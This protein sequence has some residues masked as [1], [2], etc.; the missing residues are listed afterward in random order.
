[1]SAAD[2]TGELVK[3]V[4]LTCYRLDLT[5][6]AAGDNMGYRPSNSDD[7]I[8]GDLGKDFLRGG[9]GGHLVA[10]AEALVESYIGYLERNNPDPVG[11]ERSDDA[12]PFNP[13]NAPAYGGRYAGE[14]GAYQEFASMMRVVLPGNRLYF[15]T[16]DAGE[17]LAAGTNGADASVY[18]DGN[19]RLFGD[20]GN[21]WIVGGTGKSSAIDSDQ[22]TASGGAY[23]VSP[24]K[25]GGD[26]AAAFNID[27]WL[28]YFELK[29]S[30]VASKPT[31][32][33]RPRTAGSSTPASAVSQRQPATC[34]SSSEQHGYRQLKGRCG[35]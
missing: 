35:E 31:A 18:S 6:D 11:V 32:A 17:S 34:R 3:A 22:V 9:A 10:G 26:A 24:T 4:N 16:F 20:F 27:E 15:S 14:F 25:L 8:Y 2:V 28:T 23:Q 13:G 29:V 33:T 21:D 5:P 30:I 12:G 1:V 19:A 7:I